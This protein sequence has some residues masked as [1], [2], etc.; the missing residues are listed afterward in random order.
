MQY[1]NFEKKRLT[2]QIIYLE[3]EV[4]KAKN[5]GSGDLEP[6][7][8][9]LEMEVS[10]INALIPESASA[11]NQLATLADIPQGGGADIAINNLDT[12]YEA[13]MTDEDG[14]YLKVKIGTDDIYTDSV[15]FEFAGDNWKAR[16]FDVPRQEAFDDLR[17][18]AVVEDEIDIDGNDLKKLV[19]RIFDNG[20]PEYNQY[21]TFDFYPT[22]DNTMDI[23]AEIRGD[24]IEGAASLLT[25]NWFIANV[26]R[27]IHYE[28]KKEG[29]NTIPAILSD[30]APKNFDFTIS[31]ALKPYYMI[32]GIVGFESKQGST[33]VPLVIC[34]QFTMSESSTLRIGFKAASDTDKTINSLSV[35]LLLIQRSTP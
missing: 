31:D 5:N 25:K 7:V 20:D 17:N 6:R 2:D 21:L 16:P 4:R 27:P 8:D 1:N 22:E 13:V 12:G 26:K 18:A 9:E 32:G 14:D 23:K 15:R 19:L 24:G 28:I 3:S 11:E 35:K 33:R 34:Q 30:T 10:N 29:N